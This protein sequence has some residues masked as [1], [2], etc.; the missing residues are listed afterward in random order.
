MKVKEIMTAD[1]AVCTAD[2]SIADAARL[3][4][5]HDCGEIPVV[6]NRETRKPVGV[7]TDRDIACRAV[8]NGKG[9]D[10]K[11]ADVMSN[12]VVTCEPDADVQDCI[13]KMEQ[14]QLRRIPIVDA[15]GRICGIVAQ[16]DLAN[17]TSHRETA[18]VV[19]DVSQ[20]TQVT[21]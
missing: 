20:P 17:K 11:V 7:I 10:T 12:D 9:P 3:M 4:S 14:Y 8:A 6:D 1:P 5:T 16:A 21:L 2:A 15:Q 13:D 18:R 19:R